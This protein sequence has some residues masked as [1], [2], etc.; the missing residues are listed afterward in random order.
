MTTKISKILTI[1]IVSVIIISALVIPSSAYV[2]SSITNGTKY[3]PIAFNRISFY[4]Q[5]LNDIDE[6]TTDW[7]N[8]ID[9]ALPQTYAYDNNA[10]DDVDTQINYRTDI[11]NNKLNETD[12]N[13]LSIRQYLSSHNEKRTYLYG[14]LYPKQRRLSCIEFY[15]PFGVLDEHAL[16]DFTTFYFTSNY[17]V[18]FI[19]AQ[20]EYDILE[21]TI[22]EYE[23]ESTVGFNAKTF[24]TPL[25]IRHEDDLL[26]N[27]RFNI[28][29]TNLYNTYKDIYV[30]LDN[31]LNPIEIARIYNIKIKIF[32]EPNIDYP[33]KH[34]YFNYSAWQ[35]D[36]TI[37]MLEDSPIVSVPTN[38]TIIIPPESPHEL[39]WMKII[40]DNI[41]SLLEIQIFPNFTLGWLLWIVIGL[42][43]LF[44]FLKAFLGG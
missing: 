41:N 22:V 2:T 23:N 33:I 12:N 17:G 5:T 42:S 27:G 14:D 44:I 30:D 19:E 20:L 26:N 4:G 25:T 18:N 11:I 34:I 37:D 10:Y 3:F 38:N 6:W 21:P 35:T 31:P 32:V 29:W 40:K 7:Y 28:S 36:Y 1:C 24:T 16:N 43:T 8:H 13:H 15:A 9:V 39:N